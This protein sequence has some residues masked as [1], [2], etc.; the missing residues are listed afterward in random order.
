MKSTLLDIICKNS[1][2]IKKKIETLLPCW[3][4]PLLCPLPPQCYCTEAFFSCFR[5]NR[6][7]GGRLECSLT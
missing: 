2:T 7:D 6:R 1:L 4:M 5:G 3:V